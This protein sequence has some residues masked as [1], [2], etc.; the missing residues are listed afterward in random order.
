MH[1]I[2][3]SGGG[4]ALAA[5]LDLPYLGSIPLDTEVR[6]SGDLGAPTTVTAPD[7]PAGKAFQAIADQVAQAIGLAVEA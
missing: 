3:G 1:D 6:R 7:S 2:F 5:A 4:E